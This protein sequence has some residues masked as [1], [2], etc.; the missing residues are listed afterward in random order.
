MLHIFDD[1][2]ILSKLNL[3]IAVAVIT[4]KCHKIHNKFATTN[5]LIFLSEFFLFSF[6]EV[7]YL[8]ND[9][10]DD[11][12]DERSSEFVYIQVVVYCKNFVRIPP[13]V[14]V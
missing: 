5:L 9:D 8:Q 11:D 14:A 6:C 3:L 7:N 10:E 4:R 1:F 2:L 13:D 12:D